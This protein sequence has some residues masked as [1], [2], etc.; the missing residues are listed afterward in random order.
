MQRVKTKLP[1]CGTCRAYV[2]VRNL[3][4]WLCMLLWFRIAIASKA[5]QNRAEG[6]Q[7]FCSEWNKPLH[8]KQVQTKSAIAPVDESRHD[9]NNINLANSAVCPQIVVGFPWKYGSPGQILPWRSEKSHDKDQVD[10]HLYSF[11]GVLP[12][13][14]STILAGLWPRSAFTSWSPLKWILHTSCWASCAPLASMRALAGTGLQW[15]VV[16]GQARTLPHFHHSFTGYT[17]S[18]N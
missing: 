14:P 7:S 15:R 11:W 17:Y 9:P 13:P 4:A 3:H 2:S 16:A 5:E 8:W 1:I 18:W 12:E 6:T 10:T